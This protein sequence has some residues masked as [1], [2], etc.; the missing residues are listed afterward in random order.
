MKR[1]TLFL[2]ATLITTSLAALEPEQAPVA[3]EQIEGA[4]TALTATHTISKSAEGTVTTLEAAASSQ[5]A[6]PVQQEPEIYLNF[7]D[8]SLAS[9]LNYLTDRQNVDVI[10]HKDLQNV[11]V[12]LMSRK[13]MTLSQAWEA[14]YTLL[15]ANGFTIATVNGVHRVVSM[16]EHQQ[17]PLPCYSSAKGIA[18]EDLEDSNKVIRYIYFCS[19]ISVSVAQG[20]LTPLL[21]ERSV[22]VN[23]ALQACII[24]EKSLSIKTAMRIVRELDT[25]GLRQAIKIKQ[26]KHTNAHHITRLFNEH[27]IQKNQEQQGRIRVITTEKKHDPS[28]FSKDTKIIP[29]VMHNRLILMGTNDAIDKIIDFVDKYLDVPLSAKSRL[30]VRECKYIA[31]EKLKGILERIIQPQAAR[32][33][34]KAQRKASTASLKMSSLALKRRILETNQKVAVD[35][36]TA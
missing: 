26:L 22:Q 2:I 9:V 20:I 34:S 17:N 15:E 25:G 24:T 18:P 36:V 3:Q 13:P 29:D 12:S 14:L 30:H 35:L 19:N 7:N 6:P 10:P 27:I 11:K 31:A 1:Y 4:E 28:H 32:E 16:Q 23:S 21:A 33:A 5:A 8:A